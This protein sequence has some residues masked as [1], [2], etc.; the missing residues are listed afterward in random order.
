MQA[1]DLVHMITDWYDGA[2]EG[3]ADLHG[4][5]HYFMN[6]W[7]EQAGYWTETYFLARLDAETFELA[8]ESWNIWLRWESAFNE[9]RTTQETH[10]A[11]PADRERREELEEVLKERLVADPD[12]SLRAKGSS[13]TESHQG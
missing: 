13:S 9:G 2:R 4:A 5:P 11:I 1:A 3:V 6:E 7:D 12:S 10:R 8:V